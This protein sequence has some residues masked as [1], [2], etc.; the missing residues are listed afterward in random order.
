MLEIKKTTWIS[1]IL[2]WLYQNHHELLNSPVSFHVINQQF[3]AKKDDFTTVLEKDHT[4]ILTLMVFNDYPHRMNYWVIGS[5]KNSFNKPPHLWYFTVFFSHFFEPDKSEQKYWRSS[6]YL[7]FSRIG[8]FYTRSGA[9][10]V[11]NI[12]RF[13]FEWKSWKTSTISW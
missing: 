2:C 9:N 4:N 11:P 6:N 7:N 1:A 12:F 5:I 13:W 10:P 3:Y 8:T